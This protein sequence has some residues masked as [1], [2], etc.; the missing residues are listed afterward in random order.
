MNQQKVKLSVVHQGQEL[1]K[2]E[3]NF[4]APIN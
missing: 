3:T 2:I 4:T 1:D